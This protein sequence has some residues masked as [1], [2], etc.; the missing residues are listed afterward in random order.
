[1]LYTS[2]LYTSRCFK[3]VKAFLKLWW[4]MGQIGLFNLTYAFTNMMHIIQKRVRFKMTE[5]HKA[6]A[7]PREALPDVLLHLW[8]LNV[9]ASS[10]LVH[11]G[12]WSI[13]RLGCTWLFLRC[14]EVPRHALVH[15]LIIE[16][17]HDCGK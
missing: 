5:S 12:H 6:E 3:T 8:P 11:N 9:S 13:S 7:S 17:V 2:R 14:I 15:H 16:R 10:C 1:M 4:P